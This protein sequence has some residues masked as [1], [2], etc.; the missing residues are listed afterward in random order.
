[1]IQKPQTSRSTYSQG[2]STH[3]SSAFDRHDQ[4][5]PQ[6][7]KRTRRRVSDRVRSPSDSSGT[8]SDEDDSAV[9]S[10]LSRQTSEPVDGRKA[11]PAASTAIAP[12]G[13]TAYPTRK[14]T[15]SDPSRFDSP[16]AMRVSRG[17]TAPPSSFGGFA[18]PAPASRRRR[19][20]Q[21]DTEDRTPEPMPSR[22]GRKST[23]QNANVSVTSP[24]WSVRGQSVPTSPISPGVDST[25]FHFRA[26]SP[27]EMEQ[28]EQD[29]EA[30]ELQMEQDRAQE[31]AEMNDE[32][33]ETDDAVGM[34]GVGGE[35]LNPRLSRISV[36]DDAPVIGSQTDEQTESTNS[37]RTS[38]DKLQA[39][40]K[41]NT[42]LSRK[43]KESERQL[44][45]LGWV[46]RPIGSDST[47]VS[48]DNDRLVIDL[49]RQLEEARHE[50]AQ[51]RKDDKELR[52]H[53]LKQNIQISGV[54][55]FIFS[56]R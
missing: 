10:R 12:A 29:Q 52:G 45:L 27:E 43:L 18:R 50:L 25:S 49:E 54:S 46:L 16:L 31:D 40:Q 4:S 34:L 23:S 44:A 9:Y 17:G 26:K 13:G 51:K 7:Q 22:T 56:R 28:E 21:S 53:E 38:H 3:P 36:S 35:A 11:F 24:T 8:S 30:A 14:K 5:T 1:M 20:S 39:L 47:D 15:L 19:G 42:D 6:A 55:S 2:S 48:A 33:E 32:V 41:Q 37:L